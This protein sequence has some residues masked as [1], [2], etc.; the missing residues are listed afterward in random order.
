MSARSLLVYSSVTGNTRRLAEAVYQAMPEGTAMFPVKG[1][2]GRLRRVGLAG[3]FYTDELAGLSNAGGVAAL[4]NAAGIDGP[5]GLEEPDA[6]S[7]LA[8]FDFIALGFWVYR[9]APDPLMLRYMSNIRGKTVALFGTLA[10]WPDSPHAA[11]VLENAARALEGNNIIL[12]FL[13]QGAL[14]PRRMALKLQ[15]PGSRHPMTPERL[16]RLEEAARHPNEQDF[17]RARA[18]FTDAIT[19]SGITHKLG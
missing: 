12:S 17:T 9:A 11:K 3:S 13:C 7:E 18:A 2:P 10:A 6:P 14:S 5:G 15:R 8:G 1:A 16:A 19:R 4:G